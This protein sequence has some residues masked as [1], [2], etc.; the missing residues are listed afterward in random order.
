M[1]YYYYFTLFVNTF[2]T[3]ADYTNNANVKFS[4]TVLDINV[5][6]YVSFIVY[7]IRNINVNC[8]F[9]GTFIV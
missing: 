8:F 6:G 9:Y 7:I 1:S 4:Y 2:N 3:F 5:I